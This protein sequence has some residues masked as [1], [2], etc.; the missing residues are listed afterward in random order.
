MK[1]IVIKLGTGILSAGHG[2]S[3][4]PDR[5]PRTKVLQIRQEGVETHYRQ[6]GCRWAWHG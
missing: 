4:R 6:F 2:N 1:K 5:T 3:S